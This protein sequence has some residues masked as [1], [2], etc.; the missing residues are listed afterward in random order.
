MLEDVVVQDAS[1]YDG[2]GGGKFGVLGMARGKAASTR[3][4]PAMVHGDDF[5]VTGPSQGMNQVKH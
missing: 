5:I 2:V 3:F 1:C 4:M